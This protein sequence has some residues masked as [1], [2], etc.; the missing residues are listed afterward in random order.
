MVQ[1]TQ[2]QSA[3]HAKADAT[4]KAAQAAKVAKAVEEAKAA[5]AAAKA[6][7]AAKPAS[8]SSQGAKGEV[9]TS[10]LIADAQKSLSQKDYG[11]AIEL[12]KQATAQE[13]S[14]HR[15]W[16][17][18]ARAYDAQHNTA[19]A[20]ECAKKACGLSKQASYQL[21]LGDMLVKY[22]DKA[23]AKMAYEVAKSLGANA[24]SVDAKLNAL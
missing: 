23:G 14:N 24:A 10:K 15:A 22:G 16:F 7:Q 8:S 13:P 4:E 17:V 18:M 19:K 1:A 3:N 21:F 5:E 2:T 12:L 6:A 11:G 9:S 20:V